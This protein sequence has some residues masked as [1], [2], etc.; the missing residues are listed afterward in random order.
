[1]DVN[2]DMDVLTYNQVSLC[3]LI[4]LFVRVWVA[5]MFRPI[6]HHPATHH[7]AVRTAKPLHITRHDQSIDTRQ[8]EFV[9]VSVLFYHASNPGVRA[10]ARVYCVNLYVWII[11]SYIYIRDCVLGWLDR[12]PPISNPPISKPRTPNSQT[13]QQSPPILRPSSPR[14]TSARSSSP[15]RPRTRSST[16]SPPPRGRGKTR[17]RCEL[18]YDLG[19]F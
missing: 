14:A 15:T 19:A 13:P 10:C 8:E 3:V 11:I 1:M 4:R 12:D 18:V 6:D 2:L 5:Y 16:P 7:R 17:G 9:N